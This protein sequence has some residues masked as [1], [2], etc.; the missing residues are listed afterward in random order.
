MKLKQD[1][2]LLVAMIDHY[3]GVY[4]DDAEMLPLFNDLTPEALTINSIAIGETGLTA[5]ISSTEFTAPEVKYNKANL[6]ASL[7]AWELV[8]IEYPLIAAGAFNAVEEEGAYV[9]KYNGAETE[10]AWVIMRGNE[11]N[12]PSEEFDALIIETVKAHCLY[13]L[14]GVPTIN[15][16]SKT[17]SVVLNFDG[18]DEM[19]SLGGSVTVMFFEPRV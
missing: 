9:T 8:N 5:S 19:S 18:I 4:A 15:E 12:I 7:S 10:S 16:G 1:N 11:D 14:E 3:K 6:G 13:D 2:V 17:D